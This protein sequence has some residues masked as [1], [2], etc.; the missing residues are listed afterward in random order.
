MTRTATKHHRRT[1]T[2]LALA[3]LIAPIAGCATPPA[4]A[5]GQKPAS[6]AGVVSDLPEKDITRWVMPLD[7]YSAAS[8][9]RLVNYAENRRMETCLS[10][11]GFS[12]PIP[13]EPTDDASYLAFPKNMSAFPELTVEIARQYGY[14]ANYMPG[15][16]PD[17]RSFERLNRI[18]ASTPGLDTTLLACRDE[19]RKTFDGLKAGDIFN[20]T[21]MWMYE[22][23]EKVPQDLVVKK[24][25]ATWKRCITAAGYDVSISAPVGDEGEQMPTQK[26]G[27]ELG[28]YAPPP[29]KFPTGGGTYGDTEV[30]PDTAGP[31]KSTPAE[32][33]L[34]V[35]DAT[36]RD[37]SGWTKAYYDAQWN[38]EFRV[39]LKH[40]DQLKKMK[41]D[42]ESLTAQARQI[43]ADNPPLH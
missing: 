19:S 39:V 24:A 37:S 14:T 32:I 34:A 27:I 35:A 15:P 1:F 42:I 5:I 13:V 33:E 18:G 9:V 20:T 7:E 30:D 38:A 3:A 4:S 10:K 6:T 25:A 22:E 23:T 28:F 43:I 21:G 31:R 29:T 8:L 2:V 16:E 36:C 17:P 40:A 26:L 11:D 12:W 41:A